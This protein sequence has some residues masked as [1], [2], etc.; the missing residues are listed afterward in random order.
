MTADSVVAVLEYLTPLKDVTPP[1]AVATRLSLTM[2]LSPV[3][4]SRVE[5]NRPTVPSRIRSAG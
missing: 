4:H 1:V 3:S 2:L 5:I